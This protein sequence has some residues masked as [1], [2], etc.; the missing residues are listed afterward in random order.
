MPSLQH[1]SSRPRSPS[2]SPSRTRSRSKSQ[3]VR[4]AA[5]ADPEATAGARVI[6]YETLGRQRP[7]AFHNLWSELGFCFALLGSMLMS[8][9]FISGFHI[10]LPPLAVE[11]D[12]PKASQTWPSSVFSLITGAFLLPFGRLGDMYGGYLVFNAGLIWMLLWCLVAGFSQ[13]YIMLI[14]CR[15]LQGLGCAAFLPAGIMLL[16]KTYRP[17]PRKNLIFAIYG[18]FAPLGFFFGILFGGIAGEALTWRWYFFLGTIILA[19]VCVAAVVCVPR[20]D[21]TLRP[22]TGL[23]MDWWGFATIV[24]GLILVVYAITDSSQAPG[25]WASPRILALTW[26]WYFFLG[27]IILAVV[28]VAAVVCVPRG[29]VT[30][31]P[32]TGLR[33]DWW[34]FAT[35]VPGLILVVCAITDSSQAPSG[36]AS[37]R[38]LVTLVLGVLLLA[39]AWYVEAR[40]ASN[41]S[42]APGGW[43]SPRILVTLLLGVLLLAA[44]W[45][46]EARVASNPLLP[47]DLFTN[48][49][50][51]VLVVALFFGYGTFGLFLFYSTFYIELVVGKP[52]LLTALWYVPMIVGGL[53]IGTVGGFTLHLLPGRVLLILAGLGN[54]VC[55]LLF[56][57]MPADPNYWAWVFPAM[58]AATIGIDITF[59]VSNVFITTNLPARRQ[60]L[61]GALIN[62]TLFLG[63][64]FFLGMG[65]VAVGQTSYKPLKDNYQVA[66][67]LSVAT[68][69]VA[70]L[71]FAFI[72]IGHAKS[73]LTLEEREA[74]EKQRRAG[75]PDV[76]AGGDEE[77]EDSSGVAVPAPMPTPTERRS[78]FLD[79]EDEK[80]P[81]A[82]RQGLGETV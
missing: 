40:V 58:I 47:A 68:A 44:A 27:T 32:P 1:C 76:S 42:Q 60:G 26:R 18:A 4:T 66:F 31:R 80:A 8:E 69:V 34:G 56:A 11:L 28:C 15:A 54:L 57:L 75:E 22:P 14:V 41:P 74:M 38:I 30:L 79:G 78:A 19:V 63:M 39:A 62:S 45:Y 5:G 77:S 43:A 33:M 21:V 36:W 13:N 67:F 49:Y 46:V 71:L 70:L 25:G 64:S 6:D 12:I 81:A 37:P 65:D 29:D 48:P 61:A 9:F 16:G 59:T 2:P 50:M 72:R 10:I 20:S 73:D 82:P 23:R 51:R 53:V 24:P 55:V 35:I 3:T 17:G 52:P 7:A